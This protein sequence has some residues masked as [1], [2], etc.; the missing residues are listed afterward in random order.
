[1][2]RPS[3]HGNCGRTDKISESNHSLRLDTFRLLFGKA[4]DKSL[5][6]E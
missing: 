3:L 6:Y 5:I 1:L 2:G 4:L